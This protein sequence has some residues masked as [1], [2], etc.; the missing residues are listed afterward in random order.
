MERN[1]HPP[2]RSIP[3]E[4]VGK[5]EK[6][7]LRMLLDEGH[8]SATA[9][10]TWVVARLMPWAA[11]CVLGGA[12]RHELHMSGDGGTAPFDIPYPSA[13]AVLH[14]RVRNAL[15]VPGLSAAAS[16][17]LDGLH[18]LRQPIFRAFR[19]FDDGLVDFLSGRSAPDVSIP[20]SPF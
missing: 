9:D 11:R 8:R 3:R 17:L 18:G 6:T 1:S 14:V 2:R 13:R 20:P 5:P 16:A 19:Y 15:A 12:L 7:R 4:P 10:G